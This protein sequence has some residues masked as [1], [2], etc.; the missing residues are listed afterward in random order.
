MISVCSETEKKTTLDQALRG[1]LGDQIV[2]I[3]VAH[4]PHFI[5]VNDVNKYIEFSLQVVKQVSCDDYLALIYLS[6][7]C[8]KEGMLN[9]LISPCLINIIEV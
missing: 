9:V 6:I 7:D 1:V 8:V 3:N 2:S 4:D 5:Q